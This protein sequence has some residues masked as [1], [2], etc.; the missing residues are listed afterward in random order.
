ML[1]STA[2]GKL[3]PPVPMAGVTASTILLAAGPEAAHG[4]PEGLILLPLTGLNHGTIWT[5]HCVPLSSS[6]RCGEHPLHLPDSCEQ[7]LLLRIADT[8][9]AKGFTK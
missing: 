8:K 1:C 2:M 9:N 3:Q 7:Q 4:L 6:A 5:Q